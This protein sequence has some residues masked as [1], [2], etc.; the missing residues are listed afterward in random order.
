MLQSAVS[1][2]LHGENLCSSADKTAKQYS[3]HPKP[4][5]SLGWEV[6]LNVISF[7]SMPFC[8][9]RD[10]CL[11]VPRNRRRHPKDPTMFIASNERII[12]RGISRIYRGISRVKHA[13]GASQGYRLLLRKASVDDVARFWSRAPK[14]PFQKGPFA[15]ARCRFPRCFRCRHCKA[16]CK[17][18]ALMCGPSLVTTTG[19]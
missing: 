13:W 7:L 1:K 16:M 15:C 5:R 10:R 11:G 9:S 8:L 18:P 17:R 2:N 6:S 19:L 12:Y 3:Q 4:T 14:H